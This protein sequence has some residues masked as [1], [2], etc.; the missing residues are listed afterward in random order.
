MESSES[1]PTPGSSRSHAAR[2][3]SHTR[4]VQS[5]EAVANLASVGHRVTARTA[6]L[7][8]ARTSFTLFSVLCQYLTTPLASPE[9]RKRPE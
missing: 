4:T 1:K 9:S 7:G 5:S 3:E 8:C 2:A 6:A